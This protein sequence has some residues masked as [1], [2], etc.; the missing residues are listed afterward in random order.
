KLSD[1]SLGHIPQVRNDVTAFLARLHAIDAGSLSEADQLDQALLARSLEDTAAGIDLKTYEM[2]VDQYNGI[3][4]TLPQIP[5]YA[6]FDTV[7]HYEDYI[8]R[9]KQVPVSLDRTTE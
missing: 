1:V 2:P 5:T 7:K 9:L 4:L 6:P 3:H 8:A